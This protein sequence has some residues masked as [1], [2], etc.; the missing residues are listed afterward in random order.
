MQ[1]TLF[2]NVKQPLLP[3]LFTYICYNSNIKSK[4]Y[5]WKPPVFY[6]YIYNTN[7]SDFTESKRLAERK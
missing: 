5:K 2:T 4:L 7:K 6:V 3:Y 1:I